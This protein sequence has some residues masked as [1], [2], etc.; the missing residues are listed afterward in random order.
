[1]TET[2][3]A[4]LDAAESAFAEAGIDAASLRSIMRDAGANP[5]AV[6]YHY[7]S[8]EQ[9]ALAVL[10]RVLAPLQQRRLVLLDAAVAAGAPTARTLVEAL[11]RPDFEALAATA[12][13][14]P[15]ATRILGV[16]YSR[17]PEFV[18]HHVEASFGPVA[19]MFMPHLIAA[20]PAV[21]PEDLAWRVRWNLFGMLGAVLSDTAE[22]AVAAELEVVIQRTVDAATGALSAPTTTE[23]SP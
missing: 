22:H 3:T 17:P 7:G 10:D 12:E 1:M 19:A 18:L 6:H 5:A 14:N 13:R 16:I 9:L 11:V 23:M 20:L 2:A 4:L 8:R 21:E 15:R